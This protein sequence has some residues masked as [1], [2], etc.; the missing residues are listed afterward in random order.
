MLRHTNSTRKPPQAIVVRL[1][2][3]DYEF[4]V[5]PNRKGPRK[6]LVPEVVPHVVLGF[7]RKEKMCPAHVGFCYIYIYI[8]FLNIPG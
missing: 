1:V 2:N 6:F 3:S 8:L 4:F 7:F 5:V